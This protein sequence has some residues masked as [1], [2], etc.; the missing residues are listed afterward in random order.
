MTLRGSG[1]S[2]A[3]IGSVTTTHS[4]RGE[5]TNPRRTIKMGQMTSERRV[6]LRKMQAKVEMGT[7]SMRSALS[8]KSRCG[9]PARRSDLCF[10]RASYA[11]LKEDRWSS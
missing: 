11:T 1:V 5:G 3:G 8:A 6:Q 4:L 7:A 9:S 10:V 2:D